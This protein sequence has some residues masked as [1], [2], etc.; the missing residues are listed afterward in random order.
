M[1]KQFSDREKG[2]EA[3]FE[4]DQENTFRV[5]ARGI[6]YLGMAREK[7]RLPA[8]E[9]E[10]SAKDVAL[11][12]LQEQGVEDVMRKV[13]KDTSDRGAKVSEASVRQKLTELRATAC[14]RVT[15]E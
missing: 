14:E 5:E 9:H 15:A 12:D 2:F 4:M 10:V 7:A 13:M 8:T 11:A 3:K 1:S 6:D